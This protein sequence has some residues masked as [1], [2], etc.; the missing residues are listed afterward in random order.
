MP[1]KIRQRIK[2]QLPTVIKGTATRPA[3]RRYRIMTDFF[4]KSAARH[5][6]MVNFAP[7]RGRTGTRNIL[8][9]NKM[10]EPY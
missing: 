8:Y 6:L 5:S 10:R 3:P 2:E 4:V 7:T 1:R 9:D